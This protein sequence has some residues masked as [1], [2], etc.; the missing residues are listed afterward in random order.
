MMRGMNLQRRAFNSCLL[1]LL[2]TLGWG[3]DAPAKTAADVLLAQNAPPGLDPAGYWVSEKYDG[4]RALWDGSALRF[5]S[6]RTVAAPAWFIAKLPATALDGELWMGHGTFDALSGAV[7]RAQPQDAEWQQLKYMV[8]ELPKAGGS[9]THRA[10]QL[11]SVVQAADWA[12][13]QAVEQT[14]VV[15]HAALRGTTPSGPR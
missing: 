7:R 13:L 12:Q 8:F 4:V 1:S 5:R 10:A 6:G 11:Q 2:G 3:A 15:N 14:R 9:F